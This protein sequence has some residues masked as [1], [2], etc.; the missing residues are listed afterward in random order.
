MYIFKLCKSSDK[1]FD[2][3]RTFL[4]LALLGQELLLGE[5]PR[6]PADYGPT[7]TLVAGNVE[8]ED[9]VIMFVLLPLHQEVPPMIPLVQHTGEAAT[10]TSRVL[11]F[12]TDTPRI[13]IKSHASCISLAYDPYPVQ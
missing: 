1:R 7:A 5:G 13:R 8:G 4:R 3:N 6:L 10:R 12:T 11:G 2:C 9:R